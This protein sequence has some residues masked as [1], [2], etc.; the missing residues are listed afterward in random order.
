[1][2]EG[3]LIFGKRIFFIFFYF[4]W[5]LDIVCFLI[6]FPPVL[7]SFACLLCVRR[8]E[9]SSVLRRHTSILCLEAS[10]QRVLRPNT[11]H[12]ATSTSASE[13]MPFGIMRALG[14]S[15]VW[16][17]APPSLKLYYFRCGSARNLCTRTGVA[18]SFVWFC[19]LC[20]VEAVSVSVT[21]E[22]AL[23][24]SLSLAHTH[25]LSLPVGWLVRFASRYAS[26]LTEN[27]LSLSLFLSLSHTLTHTCAHTH[28]HTHTH[29]FLSCLD[30]SSAA[31]TTI[32]TLQKK[33]IGAC[34]DVASARERLQN[35]RR[36]RL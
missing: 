27:T 31:S 23:S 18:R 25:T 24:L 6:N 13:Q 9:S 33:K 29:I 2:D 32:K 34:R 8:P 4:G 28:A 19:L 21:R 1:M 14:C 7:F 36:V 15:N 12:T 17:V 16:R 26:T 22:L 11:L 5:I 20:L 30:L 35:K 10:Q 3:F